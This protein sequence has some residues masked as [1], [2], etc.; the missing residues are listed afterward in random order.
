MAVIKQQHAAPLLKEAIVLDLGDVGRQAARMVAA[1]Q[2]KAARIVSEA[3]AKAQQLVQGASERGH[4]Q[5]YAEGL[6]QGHAQGLE[7]GQK[8]GHAQAHVAATERLNQLQKSWR[9]ALQKWENHQHDF[10][11]QA[12][13]SVLELALRLTEK[14]VHRV[15]EADPSVVVDQLGAALAHVM[16]TAEVV[17]HLSPADRDLVEEGLPSLLQEFSHLKHARLMDDPDI[18]PGGCVVRCGRGAVDATLETQ[19]ARVVDLILPAEEE[20]TADQ[21][22]SMGEAVNPADDVS[23]QLES[24]D[25]PEV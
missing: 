21:R 1:A 15:V 17:V 12:R 2:D 16:E 19:L 13:E 11:I 3:Q 7:E 4:A 5:G 20:A 24:D 6:A 9:E 22:L 25:Q 10:A 23:E 8:Q 14:I 18:T